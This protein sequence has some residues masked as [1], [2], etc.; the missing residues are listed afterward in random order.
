MTERSL[1][2]RELAERL[3]LSDGRREHEVRKLSIANNCLGVP[4]VAFAGTLITAGLIWRFG[5]AYGASVVIGMMTFT[6]WL[7]FAER[8]GMRAGY[9]VGLNRGHAIAVLTQYGVR[10]PADEEEFWKAYHKERDNEIF[11]EVCDRVF[12][13][14]PLKRS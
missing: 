7:R 3:D 5:L 14:R 12:G 11:D 8:F 13:D 9:D 4:W 10:T 2:A 6:R 1:S